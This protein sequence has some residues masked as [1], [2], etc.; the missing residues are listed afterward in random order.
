ML[1]TSRNNHIEK[2]YKELADLHN[3]KDL[4]P[5]NV[6]LIAILWDIDSQPYHRLLRICSE[7]VV[8]RG[9]NHQ[10]LRPD[11]TL[12]AEHE[13]V[14]GS[15][16]R[17]FETPDEGMFDSMIDVSVMDSPLEAIKKITTGLQGLG[18]E[19]PRDEQ[20]QAALDDARGYQVTTPYHPPT[21]LGR[22]VRYFGLAPEIDLAAIVEIAVYHMPPHHAQS[23]QRFLSDLVNKQR[24]ITSPHITLVHETNVQ[25]EKDSQSTPGI[26]QRAWEICVRLAEK[27]VSAMWT[28]N[29]THLVWDNRVM[30]L[31]VDDLVPTSQ[32]G[33]GDLKD[34]VHE[35]TKEGIHITVGTKEEEIRPYEARALV[36]MVRKRINEGEDEG[37]VEGKVDGGGKVRWAK[38]GSIHGEG[39]VKGM[40]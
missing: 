3:A 1:L 39:R 34:L 30:A 4:K 40:W 8:G 18:L 25:A 10:T 22:S 11:L 38:I 13:A 37:E 27:Q 7:R 6:R 19:V 33:Q 14:V 23:A 15:F 36:E 32:E 24:V 28:F 5:C 21:K 26:Q 9:D 16:L 12:D 17:N 20:I 2:H 31:V 35:E 29:M